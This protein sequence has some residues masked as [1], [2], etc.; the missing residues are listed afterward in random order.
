M[1]VV[2]ETERTGCGRHAMG[3]YW[4]KADIAQRQRDVRLAGSSGHQIEICGRLLVTHSRRRTAPP[5]P[6]RHG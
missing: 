5:M 2:G 4:P 6:R 1:S 3:R